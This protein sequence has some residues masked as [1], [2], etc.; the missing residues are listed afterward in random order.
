MFA[1]GEFNKACGKQDV[2]NNFTHQVFD[3]VLIQLRTFLVCF[4]DFFAKNNYIWLKIST[5]K[6]QKSS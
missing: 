1:A 5:Q 3:K 2:D 6:K 4:D